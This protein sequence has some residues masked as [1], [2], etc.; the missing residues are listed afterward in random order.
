[1]SA[2]RSILSCWPSTSFRSSPSTCRTQHRQHRMPCHGTE[3]QSCVTFPS[4]SQGNLA[5]TYA[6][7]HPQSANRQGCCC[8]GN[9]SPQRCCSKTYHL[10]CTAVLPPVSF[11]H[12]CHNDI[13]HLRAPSL[14]PQTHTLPPPEPSTQHRQH[15]HSP[16]QP[17]P[18]T[19]TG[20]LAQSVPS[21]G[22]PCSSGTADV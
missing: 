14:Q 20:C 9:L 17:H 16:A 18:S 12:T 10:R 19:Q 21:P 15:Q 2:P 22:N 11:N 1:M 3:Q 5:Q 4:K 7:T 6:L 8:Q 13:Y